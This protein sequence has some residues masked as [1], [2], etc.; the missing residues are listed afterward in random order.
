MFKGPDVTLRTLGWLKFLGNE[1]FEYFEYHYLKI[2]HK[3]LTDDWALIQFGTDLH[4]MDK[5]YSIFKFLELDA[6]ARRD[7]MLLVHS[8]EIGRAHANRIMWKLLSEWALDDQYRDLS[9][10]VSSEVGWTRMHFDRPPAGHE[11]LTWWRWSLLEYLPGSLKYFGP[12]AKPTG[13]F[14]VHKGPGGVPLAPPIVGEVPINDLEGPM[15]AF[16]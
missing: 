9:N 14:D 15:A 13:R 5:W 6:K 7:L 10:K 2:I 16:M 3:T 11:D 4:A 1:H 8:G 12:R